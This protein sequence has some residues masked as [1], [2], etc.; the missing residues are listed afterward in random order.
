MAVAAGSSF[1]VSAAPTSF[2]AEQNLETGCLKESRKQEFTLFRSELGK[3]REVVPKFVV[4]GF[5]YTEPPKAKSCRHVDS[6]QQPELGK[7]VEG[8][9]NIFER[10]SDRKVVMDNYEDWS[11]EEARR[12][13]GVKYFKQNFNRLVRIKK[14]V[15]P[16]NFFR[17]AQSI[18]FLPI[19]DLVN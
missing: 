14:K 17:N 15:D 19:D 2:V 8:G 6:R 11:Y 9:M 13:Y 4:H 12:S 1:W 10:N 5:I 18:L 3:R 7:M 16:G